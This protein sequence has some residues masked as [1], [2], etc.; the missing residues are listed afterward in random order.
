[1]AWSVARKVSGPNGL[2][3]VVEKFMPT[4]YGG[5][6]T[7]GVLAGEVVEN[8]ILQGLIHQGRVHPW[9]LR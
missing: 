1:M 3:I 4:F 7:T 6:L 9:P 8:F 2:D 5:R